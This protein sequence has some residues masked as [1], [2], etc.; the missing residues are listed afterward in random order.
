MF[1]AMVG[2]NTF[3]P[4]SGVSKK[5]TAVSH[6]TPEAEIVAADAAVRTLGMPALDL[7]T[8]ILGRTPI[9]RLMEDN[10]STIQIIK[11][12]KKPDH[13]T[14]SAYARCISQVAP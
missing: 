12:G 13:A 8:T 2:P 14:S 1:L 3:F 5:Q 11:S 6:S 10:E 9:L 7:W 4:I